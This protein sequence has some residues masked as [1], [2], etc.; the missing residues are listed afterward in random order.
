MNTPAR[1]PTPKIS[2]IIP[3][4]NRADK[5]GTAVASVLANRYPRFELLVVD[6][7]VDAATEQTL[8]PYLGDT[9][10]R[11]LHTTTTG[12]SVARNIGTRGTTGT[13]VAF[14]DDDC[15][16]GSDWIGRIVECFKSHP[17]PGG[18]FGA[19]EA[20]PGFDPA[21]GWIPTFTPG[22]PATISAPKEVPLAGPMGANMACTRHVHVGATRRV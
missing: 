22:E 16:V 11:Y 8:R 1:S 5:I 3:T 7:S 13:I 17:P 18:V 14:T 15:S 4:R 6:Q 9:R 2:V 12:L 20:A 19:V 21:L 10:F